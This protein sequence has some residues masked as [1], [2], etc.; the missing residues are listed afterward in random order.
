M[1]TSLD[2]AAQVPSNNAPVLANLC[3]AAQ[4][5]S[6][7][8]PVSANLGPAAQVPSN[9]APVSANLG[10]A[11]QVPSNNAPVSA[12]LGPVGR[13]ALNT[14]AVPAKIKG[15]ITHKHMW[16][17]KEL[18]ER[19]RSISPLSKDPEEAKRQLASSISGIRSRTLDDLGYRKLQGLI[20]YHDQIFRDEEKYDEMLLALLDALETP[21]TETRAPLGRP[22]DNKFQVLVT[23]R[24]MFIHNRKYFTAYFPRAMSAPLMARR[25]FQSRNHIVSGLEETAQDF[26]KACIPPD[27]IDAVMDVLETEERDAAGNRTIAMGLHILTGLSARL[28]EL[29]IT[30]DPLQERRM[31]KFALTCL[32]ESASVVR[33]AVIEYCL[34]LKRLITPEARFF[35]LL[36]GDID[37]LMNLITYYDAN[38]IA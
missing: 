38:K 3:P 10:P 12:N 20:S 14:S 16:Y 25:N 35:R 22:F 36:T 19:R 21:N 4:V 6:N 27:V 24:L 37:A 34:E 15:S 13:V 11:A 1:S 31:A 8:A 30:V 28:R 2:P 33:R 9:N 17:N 29:R 26:I 7:N 23:I 32:R 18:A 5:P